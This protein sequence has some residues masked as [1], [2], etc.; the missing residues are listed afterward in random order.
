[1]PTGGCP[2][3][4]A[5]GVVSD[6]PTGR[7]LDLVVPAAFGT[8]VSFASCAGVLASVVGDAV[9]DIAAMRRY[10]AAGEL[11][12]LVSSDHQFC[13]VCRR[14]VTSSPIVHRP[15]GNRIGEDAPPDASGSQFPGHCRGD[16]TVA[17]KFGRLVVGIKQRCVRNG[18]PDIDR[19]MPAPP[20][21]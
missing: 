17:G 18:D 14:S 15:A 6:R 5:V 21:A 16:G 8:E 7:L 12:G 1:M 3:S 2:G 11:A 20:T 10:P 4:A 19:S 13:E 9:V